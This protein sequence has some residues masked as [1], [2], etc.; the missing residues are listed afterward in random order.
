MA[1]EIVSFPI[2]NGGSFHNY[3]SLPEGNSNVIKNL[4]E[5]N[6]QQDGAPVR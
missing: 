6:S 4:K 1:I 2:E 3:V 5:S